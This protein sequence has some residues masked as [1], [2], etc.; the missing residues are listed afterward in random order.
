MG[1]ESSLWVKLKL[2]LQKPQARKG[3][4]F[5][6]DP[7][8]SSVSNNSSMNSGLSVASCQS[9]SSV[10]IISM[11]PNDNNVPV[12]ISSQSACLAVSP[13][14]GVDIS[15]RSEAIGVS[16]RSA[17]LRSAAETTNDNSVGGA[18]ITLAQMEV[19]ISR[20]TTRVSGL[21]EEVKE[22]KKKSTLDLSVIDNF[23]F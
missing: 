4:G 13:R 16:P 19:L 8:P 1:V 18:H 3:L 7:V 10:A 14:S 15:P 17:A 6:S 23:E 11:A 12:Y 5:G 2:T 9:V 20:L 21:E 22:L